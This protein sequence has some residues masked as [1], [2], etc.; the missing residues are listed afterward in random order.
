MDIAQFYG[1]APPE[2]NHLHILYNQCLEVA[3]NFISYSN[4][5]RIGDNSEQGHRLIGSVSLGAT[6]HLMESGSQ[7][8]GPISSLVDIYGYYG[9][10]RKN[11]TCR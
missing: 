4:Q 2:M 9:K 10:T 6:S 3:R 11:P 8:N 7:R 1:L 5:I